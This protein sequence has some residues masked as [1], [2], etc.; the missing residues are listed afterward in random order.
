MYFF[1]VISI[2]IYMNNI[3]IY[4]YMTRVNRARLSGVTAV[5]EQFFLCLP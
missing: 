4:I 5:L 1:D 3:Y 2:Y